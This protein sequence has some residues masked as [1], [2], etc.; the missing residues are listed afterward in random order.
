MDNETRLEVI[1]E[2]LSVCQKMAG[3]MAS[4]DV[5]RSYLEKRMFQLERQVGITP[6]PDPDGGYDE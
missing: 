1:K 6:K 3:Y 4:A 2:E 5:V